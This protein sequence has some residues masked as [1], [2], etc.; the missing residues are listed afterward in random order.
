MAYKRERKFLESSY[1]VTATK[2]LPT[3]RQAFRLES[4]ESRFMV[5]T[6]VSKHEARVK[7]ARASSIDSRDSTRCASACAASTSLDNDKR[8]QS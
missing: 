7:E 2:L 5:T 8:F 1:W 6:L 4:K 3:G